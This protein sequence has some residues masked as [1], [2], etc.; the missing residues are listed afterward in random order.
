MI[1]FFL[2]LINYDFPQFDYQ[3]S[4]NLLFSLLSSV[5][6]TDAMLPG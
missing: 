5:K 2:L 6:P 1:I 4:N 3:I